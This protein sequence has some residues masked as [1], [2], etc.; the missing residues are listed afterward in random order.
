MIS[1]Q[2]DGRGIPSKFIWDGTDSGGNLLP[3][4]LYYYTISSRDR[5]GNSTSA[6][7]KEIILITKM[8]I[9]DVRTETSCYSFKT[10]KGKGIRFFPELSS[11]KGL[12]K[13]E[14]TVYEDEKKPL[15][16]IA[17]A[18]NLPAF[19]DW[20]CRD[21]SGKE[22]DDGAYGYRFS[23]WYSSGNN[24]V[25]F[26]KKILF[27]STPPVVNISHEPDLFSP[28]GD[29]ENDFL[30][31]NLNGTDNTVIERW[32]IGIF[33]ESGILFKK[34]S[35]RGG[36]PSHLKW[37]GIGDDG[38]LVESASD[39]NV[40]F[41]AVDSAGNVSEKGGDK[42]P[43]DVLVVVTERGLKIR[44]SNIEFAFGSSVIRKRGTAIL[45]RV[46]QI[47]EKYSLYDVVVEGH[48]DDIG[49]EEYNLK[50][51]EKRA[52]AVREYLTSKGTN[53]GRLSYIGMGETLP[54]Y[55][56]TNDENRRRNRR[57]EFLLN[58]KKPE[59]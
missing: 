23:A 10:N 49:T 51:S 16:V 24:P 17:G 32:E 56:N 53:P 59:L 5:A 36:V 54:F 38:E 7:L 26:P 20:N 3:D 33:N 29:D 1:Y 28:D 18:A 15:V 57:V 34:F 21:A 27:D 25:S 9:A 11:V 31:L 22:L 42:I 40:Q 58:K 13:W 4:G 30:T 47:L 43:V 37:D 52:M 45:D 55:P 41:T 12:E 8:E 50:L 2:W 35:G 44:I 19:I 14:L 48:T 46:Y 6:D 39:Y